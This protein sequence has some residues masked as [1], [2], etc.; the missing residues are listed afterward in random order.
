MT[1]IKPVK[2]FLWHINGLSLY[3]AIVIATKIKPSENLTGKIFSHRKIPDLRYYASFILLSLHSNIAGTTHF[4][5]RLWNGSSIYYADNL[6]HLKINEVVC[7][8]GYAKVHTYKKDRGSW[9]KQ[10][11]HEEN[12]A[13]APCEDR[14][15]MLGFGTLLDFQSHTHHYSSS[16]SHC[17]FYRNASFLASAVFVTMKR[18]HTS[19]HSRAATRNHRVARRYSS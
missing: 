16:N 11:T 7:S 8:C 5:F 1:K 12:A 17:A 15:T 6:I 10:G 14:L 18:R 2:Y 3:C 13:T 4:Q 9:I 19:L